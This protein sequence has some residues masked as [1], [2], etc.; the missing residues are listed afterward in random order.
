MELLFD[1]LS[2]TTLLTWKKGASVVILLPGLTVLV[3]SC[4]RCCFVVIF[5]STFVLDTREQSPYAAQ[6]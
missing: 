2:P 4:K 1:P 5:F 6:G 3:G